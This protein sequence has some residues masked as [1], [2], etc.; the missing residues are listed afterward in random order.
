MVTN[1]KETKEAKCN[2]RDSLFRYHD[3][4]VI[5]CG[6]HRVNVCQTKDCIQKACLNLFLI[7]SLHQSSPMIR[8]LS[9]SFGHGITV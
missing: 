3:H 7:G 2:F 9:F 6:V 1:L 5:H 4:K 8:T